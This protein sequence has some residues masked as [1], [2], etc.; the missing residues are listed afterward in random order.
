MIK[1]AYVNSTRPIFLG[2]SKQLLLVAFL[3]KQVMSRLQ[4]LKMNFNQ[5]VYVVVLS[6]LKI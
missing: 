5:Y 3:D 2:Q 1:C 4:N 6:W